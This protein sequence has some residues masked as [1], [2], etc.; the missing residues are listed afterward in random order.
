MQKG[1][2]SLLITAVTLVW[3]HNYCPWQIST[4]PSPQVHDP[5]LCIVGLPSTSSVFP[6]N[7]C[8]D[9]PTR[10]AAAFLLSALFCHPH[11]FRRT[12][13]TAA[14]LKHYCNC[15]PMSLALPG[16]GLPSDVQFMY[17]LRYSWNL[18][19]KWSVV[20]QPIFITTT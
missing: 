7:R 1:C 16:L 17:I 20:G 8:I 4:L 10:Q 2:H 18:C 3:C 6:S 19:C 15:V 9:E 11:F 12:Q 5:E 14:A 13:H